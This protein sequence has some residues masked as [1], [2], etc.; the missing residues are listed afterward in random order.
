MHVRIQHPE[1]QDKHPP[2]DAG[3]RDPYQREVDEA[4]TELREGGQM[5]GQGAAP[6]LTPNIPCQG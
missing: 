1:P 5:E 6:V 3:A 2:T 4:A